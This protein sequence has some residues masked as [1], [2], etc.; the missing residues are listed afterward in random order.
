MQS[1]Y[2]NIKCLKNEFVNSI[3]FLLANCRMK[4]LVSEQKKWNDG[5]KNRPNRR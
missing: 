3:L 1:Y 4:Q 2:I 5:K